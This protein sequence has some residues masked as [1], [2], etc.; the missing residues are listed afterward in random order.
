VAGFEERVDEILTVLGRETRA[1]VV[2]NL[3]PDIAVTPRFRASEFRDAV[4]RQAVLFNQ[5]LRRQA[6]RHGAEVVDLYTP[7]RREVPARPEL[8]AG[9]GYH[10]SDVGYERWATLMWEGVSARVPP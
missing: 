6:D 4:A 1:V 9:D 8:L 10:P 2:V 5:A 7:S 3:L